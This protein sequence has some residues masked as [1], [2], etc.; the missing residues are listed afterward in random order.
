MDRTTTRCDLI[1][2]KTPELN[3]QPQFPKKYKPGIGIIG[4]G[5]IVKGAHLPAY[6][7][8]N[9]NIVGVYDIK[10][11][12][13]EGV[14][15][16]FGVK[17]VF[18]SVD[19]MLASPEVEVVDIATHPAQRI[20]LMRKAIAAG[21]HILAQKPLALDVNEAKKVVDE[22]DKKGIKIAVNQNGRWS[23][24]WRVAT[25]LLQQG[26]I[27]EV[28]GVTHFYDMCFNWIPGT[29]FDDVK[30][31]S[32]YDY[33]VHWMDITRCWLDQKKVKSVRARDYRVPNQPK[34][35]KAEWGMWVEVDYTDGSNGMIRGSGCAFSQCGHPFWIHGTKG[36]I[37]GSVLDNHLKN[38]HVELLTAEGVT[39]FKTEGAWFNDGFAG[40]M[41]ELLCAI[42][43]N[44]QPYNSARHN[45]LSLQLTL[46][47][48]QS[49]DKNGE[50]IEVNEI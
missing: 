2:M 15:E 22:A 36:T 10:P 29:V 35:S 47:A 23:P 24:P 8:N 48:C 13:T 31:F 45:L 3:Y 16:K 39:R 43:E 11:E 27:G 17:K 6:Q 50:V 49:A 21:K 25:L 40:A 14:T 9:L 32:I 30:H 38:D 5:G 18:K 44:R 20:E 37:R 26:A 1:S 41:G 4:C 19:E 42:E 46:A 33:S 28:T 12:A 7:K 34:G